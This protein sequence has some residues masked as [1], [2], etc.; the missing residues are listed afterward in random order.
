[1]SS[2]LLTRARVVEVLRVVALL[3]RVGAVSSGLLTRASS[4]RR[5]VMEVADHGVVWA[6]PCH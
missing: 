6:A 1:M 3:V 2:R 5:R 4:G